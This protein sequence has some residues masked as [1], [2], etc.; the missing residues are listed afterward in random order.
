MSTFAVQF[1]SNIGYCTALFFISSYQ[2]CWVF[3]YY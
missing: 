3:D 1:P 2:L